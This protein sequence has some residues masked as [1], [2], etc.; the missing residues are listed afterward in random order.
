MVPRHLET[1]GSEM[2][3]KAEKTLKHKSHEDAEAAYAELEKKLGEQGSELG[4]LRQI[5]QQFQQ[6]QAAI[7][8]YAG[9]YQQWR[10]VM[11]FYA[12]NQDF[13]RQAWDQRGQ[14]GQAGNGA[15]GMSRE[16]AA[17]VAR[18]QP[19]Y[20]LLTKAEKTALI[21]EVMQSAVMPWAQ[22][23]ERAAQ[24]YAQQVEQRMN[25]TNR[26]AMDV[27]WRTLG[28]V[29]PPDKLQSAQQWHE[30]ALK[31]ADPSKFDPMETAREWLNSRH[32]NET[33]KTKLTEL[34]KA[35]EAREKALVPSLGASGPSRTSMFSQAETTERSAPL[36]PDERFRRV[37]DTTKAEV[38]ADGLG[39]LFSAGGR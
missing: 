37:L 39:T 8:Q 6:A 17:D 25:H 5:A 32:E 24:Q 12:Q 7:Q 27:M 29:V 20:E 19:G 15:A 28:H 1:G 34:E 35:N 38:G 36:S 10:P 33:L 26:A 13:I 11:E 23:F 18:Q 9:L 14:G 22:Q 4:Q 30:Q 2:A 16:Q 3:D 31:F 21:G